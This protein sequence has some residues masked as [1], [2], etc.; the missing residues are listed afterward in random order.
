MPIRRM[1][2]SQPRDICQSIRC[3][4]PREANVSLNHRQSIKEVFRHVMYRIGL[5]GVVNAAR[6]RQ[7]QSLGHLGVLADGEASADARFKAIYDRRAWVASE[8]QISL[9]GGGSEILAAARLLDELPAVVERLGCGRLLDVGCGDWN[10]M[11]HVSLPCEYVGVDVVHDVIAGNAKYE[12]P[13]VSFQVA[14]AIVGPLPQ[15][16]ATL[17]RDVLFHLS[18]ADGKRALRNMQKSSRWLIATT[19]RSI[20]F[21]SDIQTGDFRNINL[22]RRPYSLGPAHEYIHDGAGFPGRALGIWRTSDLPV[23]RAG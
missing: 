4:S 3:V 2:L 17:C 22:E 9:S 8:G 10:W 11:R 15:A 18:F 5:S 20:W 14:D 7:G 12:R 1:R 6:Q 16:D 13:G 23:W 21:N 19:D